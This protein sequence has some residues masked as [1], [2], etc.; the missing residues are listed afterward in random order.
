MAQIGKTETRVEGRGSRAKGASVLLGV[1]L[2]LCMAPVGGCF[3]TVTPRHVVTR[4]VSFDGEEQNGGFWRGTNGQ[5]YLT[6]HGM[7][8]YA[9]LMGI[10]G[11][12]WGVGYQPGGEWYLPKGIAPVDFAVVW[13]LDGRPVV[14][15]N[16]WAIDAQHLFYFGTAARW[17]KE[18][19]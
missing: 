1:L 4:T 3:G 16:L 18:G 9:G 13:G 14:R 8:R 15:S 5:G 10:Y 7:L 12:N 11:T 2:L 6:H 19:R 17:E